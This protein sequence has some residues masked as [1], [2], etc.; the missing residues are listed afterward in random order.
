MVRRSAPAALLT[1][2]ALSATACGQATNNSADDFSGEAKAVATTIDD[3]ADAG[4]NR[5]GEEICSR[6]LAQG[7]V[8]K[9]STS[10]NKTCKTAI[11][12]SLKDVDSFDL[13]VVKKGITVNGTTAT[14]KV[15]SDSGTSKRT[16]TLQLV[17]EPRTSG[18]KTT[19]VWKLNALAG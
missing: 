17:K 2:V 10:Q 9:I 3:L 15:K 4:R 5:D 6:Y 18:G 14:A 16:D 19:Q 13:E 7:L 11:E 8:A 12:E 1:L